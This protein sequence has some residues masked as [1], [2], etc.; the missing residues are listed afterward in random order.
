MT[1]A[2]RSHPFQLDPQAPSPGIPALQRYEQ[3]FGTQAP[4]ILQRVQDEG[5]KEGLELRFDRAISANTFDAHRTLGFAEEPAPRR[6]LEMSLYRAYFTEG[7]DRARVLAYLES[8]T[9]SDE[10]R[11][12]L[13]EAAELGINGV[14]AFVFEQQYLV[15][16]AVP[17][18]SFLQIFQRLR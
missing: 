12:Q 5:A 3:K 13:Q 18:E 4:Q 2:V 14:P 7:L 16:G 1:V 10:L 17:V 9:G 15:P 11:A 6:A 8:G